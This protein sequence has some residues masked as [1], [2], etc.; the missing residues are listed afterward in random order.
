M[1]RTGAYEKIK[2]RIKCFPMDCFPSIN[3]TVG[4]SFGFV[5]HYTHQYGVAVFEICIV[6]FECGDVC[7]SLVLGILLSP[8]SRSKGVTV[9]LLMGMIGVE[10]W[11]YPAL[12]TLGYAGFKVNLF[13]GSM[14]ILLSVGICASAD[15]FFQGKWLFLWRILSMPL[16]WSIFDRVS[17]PST[18]QKRITTTWSY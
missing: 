4:W 2:S 9:G 6:S 7:S 18:V 16:A 17:N 5:F 3:R 10:Q 11:V 15:R 14:L 13:V 8:V 1:S 12:T